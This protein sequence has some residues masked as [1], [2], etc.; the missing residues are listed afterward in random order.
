MD[1]SSAISAGANA[2]TGYLAG[3]QQAKDNAFRNQL[4][5]LA[6]QN[7]TLQNQQQEIGIKQQQAMSDAAMAAF[8]PTAPSVSPT[9]PATLPG[10]APTDI[11]QLGQQPQQ[12]EDF[13]DKLDGLAQKA[14][15]VGDLVHGNQLMT[16]AANYRESKYKQQQTQAATDLAE[17]RRQQISHSLVAQTLGA[18]QDEAEWDQAK[19]EVLTSPWTTPEEKKNLANLAYSPEVVDRINR[20]GMN[21]SQ[22]AQ[23]KMKQLELEEK[24]RNNDLNQSRRDRDESR[25][26]AHE[27]AWQAHQDAVKKVGAESK[28]PS[29]QGLHAAGVALKGVAPEMDEDSNDFMRAQQSIASRAQQIVAGNKAINFDQAVNM[30]ASE[31][32]KSGEINTAKTPD[33]RVSI[34][35]HGIPGTGKAPEDKVTFKAKGNT[36]QEAIP[37]AKDMKESDLI[38]GRFYSYGGKTYQVQD[39]KLHEVH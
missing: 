36:A 33:T 19:M 1:L 26:D 23:A 35:G 16:N 17:A 37:L 13:G 14:F 2:G 10:G 22:Q 20:A 29:K 3:Q 27:A 5:S 28:A 32:Q 9:P 30:A 4:N 7:Q 34:F 6:I 38:N 18:A 21:S 8:S 11:S 15:S 24:Q 39:G 31:A 25:K 12:Q